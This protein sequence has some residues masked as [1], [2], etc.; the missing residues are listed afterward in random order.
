MTHL[1]TKKLIL[2]AGPTAA[3]KTA[4]AIRIAQHFHTSIISADSRQCYKEMKIGVARPSDE[5]LSAVPHFFI[6]SH[7]IQEDVTAAVF[8]SYALEKAAELFKTHDVVVMVGG[9]GLYIRAFCEGLDLIPEIAA[10]IREKI[11]ASYEANGIGW[12][13]QELNLRDPLFAEKG[14]MQN[15]Q[16]MMRAL[17]V[18]EATG[19][20]IFSFRRNEKTSRDFEIIKIG[21]TLPRDILRQRIDERVDQMMKAGLEAEVRELRP[22]RHL[23]ALQTV[24]Y[25]EIFEYL[26]GKCRLEDAVE[27]VK[28]NT[29][30][31]AKRQMTW[32]NRDP[33]MHWFVPDEW[34]KILQF[35]D[36][37]V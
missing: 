3:G 7:S 36:T 35:I 24:G 29:R 13:Q 15:P 37:S 26:E 20:S 5:E 17:E 8:E 6:A 31:Y 19:H 12:L 30:Q 18:V 23:N 32:F 28:I 2:I 22:N 9:T 1:S 34:D 25:Q 16:R 33:E 4:M 10:G 21:L 11:I 14:E 27:R